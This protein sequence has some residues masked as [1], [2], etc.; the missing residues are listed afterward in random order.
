M[1]RSFHLDSPAV[2]FLDETQTFYWST[3]LPNVSGTSLMLRCVCSIEPIGLRLNLWHQGGGKRSINPQLDRFANSLF[4]KHIT[5]SDEKNSS[6]CS[7]FSDVLERGRSPQ[8]G[9][10]RA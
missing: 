8:S 7:Y 9:G 1:L 6:G 2:M 3:R 4:L 10:N 5:P